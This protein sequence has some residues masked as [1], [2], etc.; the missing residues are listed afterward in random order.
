[1]YAVGA[2]IA[3]AVALLVAPGAGWRLT[4]VL[5]VIRALL[6]DVLRRA[7]RESLPYQADRAHH[8]QREGTRTP[9]ARRGR[10]S[11]P[12]RCAAGWASPR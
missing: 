9:G 10:S 5:A 12:R 8:E 3:L 7:L 6:V 11:P 4:F 1:M 2:L